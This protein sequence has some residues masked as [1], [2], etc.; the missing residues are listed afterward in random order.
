[1]LKIEREREKVKKTREAITTTI[2]ERVLRHTNCRTWIIAIMMRLPTKTNLNDQFKYLLTFDA[3]SQQIQKQ[4]SHTT[5]MKRR[6]GRRRKSRKRRRIRTN[7]RRRK[8]FNAKAATTL[9]FFTFRLCDN[10]NNN[11]DDVYEMNES[12]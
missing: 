10:N 1:M 8:H 3:H 2:G 9:L 11:D 12:N 5:E 6:S 7:E 4:Q